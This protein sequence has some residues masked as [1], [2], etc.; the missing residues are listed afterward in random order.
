MKSILTALALAACTTCAVAAPSL[1]M[2]PGLWE[3]N[4]KISSA[5]PA[6]QSAMAQMQKQLA[7]MSPEQRQAMQQM[8]ERNGMQMKVSANG[9]I[10]SRMC[11]TRE[12]IGRKEFPVQ[13]GDC[14]QSMTPVSA[15]TMKVSF[16][17]TK[18]RASGEG[19]MTLD[20]DTSYHAHMKVH[21]DERAG[22]VEADVS[23]KWQGA[24]CGPLGAATSPGA[25]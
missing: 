17:C 16:T 14:K 8:M 2:K 24:D 4:S 10:Q 7:A 23:G 22:T 25:K 20:S 11:M 9:A 12:M 21:S 18:P 5:D 6:I 15:S 13:Q 19:E 3:L 1:D